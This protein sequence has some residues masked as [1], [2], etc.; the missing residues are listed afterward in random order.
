MAKRNIKYYP[1]SCCANDH[2]L[3]IE[4][5]EEDNLLFVGLA[6]KG[7]PSF[8]QRIKNA[9]I[10]LKGHDHYVDD[11]ILDKEDVSVLMS[12][13]VDYALKMNEGE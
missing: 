1:C 3:Y 13:I 10:V 5:D 8:S 9:I 11:V 12:N 2:I 4:Y 6:I 7:T